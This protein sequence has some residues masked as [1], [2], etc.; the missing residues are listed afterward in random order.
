MKIGTMILAVMVVFMPPKI[1]ITPVAPG[2]FYV[3]ASLI[4][5]DSV[6]R[7]ILGSALIKSPNPPRRTMFNMEHII[8]IEEV[9]KE[10]VLI[11]TTPLSEY[12]VNMSFDKVMKQIIQTYRR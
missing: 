6:D 9:D 5:Y 10:T 1:E 2:V 4:E 12:F 3:E 8:L 11:T 7:G